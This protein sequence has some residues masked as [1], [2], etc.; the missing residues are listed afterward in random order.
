[1]DNPRERDVE[2]LALDIGGTKLAAGIVDRSG[3]VRDRR[4]IPTAR[5]DGADRVLERAL[6]LVEELVANE[7]RADRLPLGLGVSTNG[8]TRE[9][10]VDL[11]P[12]VPGWSQLRIP[13]AL[14]TRFPQLRA[15]IINDVKAAT[16]AELAWGALH[17]VSEGLYV[18]LGTGIAAGIVWRRQVIEGAHG[19]AGEV[20]YIVPS[21][22]ALADR[23]P[24]AAVL[25][26][27][28]GG[29]GVEAWTAT[30]RGK[31]ISARELFDSSNAS[32]IE[33]ETREQLI[34]E[35]ALWVANVAIV[36]DPSRV[37]LGGGMIQSGSELYRRTAEILGEIAPFPIDVVPAHFG[38]ESALLGAG[39]V[40]LS[41]EQTG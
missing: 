12:A 2:V 20:G 28:L 29:R 30:E 39:A 4:V 8:L 21:L 33:R 1:M 16:R 26:E 34:A 40:A 38:A 32:P 31:A 19:A 22:E 15:T 41:A 27:R 11:A 6:S 9:D 10:G 5:E 18:N 3:R 14:H 36:V 37:V 35:I 7:R 23:R 25:E 13:A 24:G 17:G